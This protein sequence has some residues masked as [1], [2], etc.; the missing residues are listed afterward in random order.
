MLVGAVL[1]RHIRTLAA[2][3]LRHLLLLAGAAARP[4]TLILV[5]THVFGSLM[6]T[7]LLLL[8]PILIMLRRWRIPFGAV[9]ILFTVVAIWL[10]A[11]DEFRLWE[12]IPAAVAGGLAADALV[13]WLMPWPGR[14]AAFRLFA[15]LVPLV[16]WSCYVLAVDLRWG[17]PSRPTCGCAAGDATTRSERPAASSH[18]CSEIISHPVDSNC[19]GSAYSRRAKIHP[20]RH[21]R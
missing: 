3:Q 12:A 7:N 17:W 9:T 6:V 21:I 10:A 11:L 13:A 20:E 15:A 18:L 14:V 2:E 16:F 1:T 8:G 5:Q 4:M 19:N